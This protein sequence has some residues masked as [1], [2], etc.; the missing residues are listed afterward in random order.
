VLQTD[1]LFFDSGGDPALDH[2]RRLTL[3]EYEKKTAAKLDL[4]IETFR[5]TWVVARCDLCWG[6]PHCDG[7]VSWRAA[8]TAGDR[9]D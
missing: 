2:E 8:Q 3:E 9:R 5:R 1:G 6:E 4:S 7:W